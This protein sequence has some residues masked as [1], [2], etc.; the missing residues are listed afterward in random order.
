MSEMPSSWWRLRP[1]DTYA[2]VDTTILDLADGAAY[3]TETFAFSTLPVNGGRVRDRTV[4]ATV[5]PHHEHRP[6]R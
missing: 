5:R 4:K 3:A 6:T 1:C 2:N